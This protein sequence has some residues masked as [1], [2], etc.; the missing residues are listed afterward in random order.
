MLGQLLSIG[1]TLK[2]ECTFDLSKLLSYSE[3]P[4]NLNM[5]YEMFLVDYNGDL[6]DVPVKINQ[7]KDTSN[8]L[9]NT[10]SDSTNWILTRRFFVVDSISGIS[11]TG[12]FLGGNMTEVVRYAKKITLKV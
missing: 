11:I 12:G 1:T 5:F 6:I 4:S 2:N 10:G 7:L 9:P 8:L 3:K